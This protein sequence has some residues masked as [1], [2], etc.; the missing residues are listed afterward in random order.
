MAKFLIKHGARGFEDFGR[1]VACE[2]RADYVAAMNEAMDREA[3]E[4]AERVDGRLVRYSVLDAPVAD[5]AA[6]NAVCAARWARPY[7]PNVEH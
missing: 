2:E 5:Q 4:G 7:G 1:F 6:W 3:A